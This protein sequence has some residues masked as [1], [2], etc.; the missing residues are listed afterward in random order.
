MTASS[1]LEWS[2]KFWTKKMVEHEAK[3]HKT[4]LE[5]VLELKANTDRVRRRR[6]SSR[7]RVL[8]WEWPRLVQKFI[9]PVEV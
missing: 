4:R 2:R 8:I 1:P 7:G 5:A 9:L 6:R 3:K